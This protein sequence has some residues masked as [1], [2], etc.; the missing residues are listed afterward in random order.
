MSPSLPKASQQFDNFNKT[1]TQDAMPNR[2]KNVSRVKACGQTRK[3]CF[4]CKT[5]Y[6]LYRKHFVALLPVSRAWQTGKL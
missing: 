4:C 2:E 5:V 1:L 6:E 3:H